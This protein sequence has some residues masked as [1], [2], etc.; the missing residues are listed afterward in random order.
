VYCKTVAKT[1]EIVG[2]LG[3]VCYYRKVESVED[4]KEIVQQLTSRQQQVFTAT[5]ALELGVDAPTIQA[6]VY[7]GT[8]QKMQYYI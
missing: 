7:I 3:G 4:K 5:N 8:V 1:V 2:E 6:V